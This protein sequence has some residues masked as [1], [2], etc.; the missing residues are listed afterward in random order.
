MHSEQYRKAEGVERTTKGVDALG[1]HA[2]GWAQ[3]SSEAG[4]VATQTSQ[5][6]IDV[7]KAECGVVTARLETIDVLILVEKMYLSA[8]FPLS[9]SSSNRSPCS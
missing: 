1:A 4:P 5:R 9:T 2:V 8:K 7:N 6:L 3:V